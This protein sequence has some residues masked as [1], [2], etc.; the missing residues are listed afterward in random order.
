[1]TFFIAACRWCATLSAIRGLAW[2]GLTKVGS[3]VT[4]MTRVTANTSLARMQKA[5]L[6]ESCWHTDSTSLW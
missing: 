6:L 5:Y 2:L 3:H 1:M 4:G